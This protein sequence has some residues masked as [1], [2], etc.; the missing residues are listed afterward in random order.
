MNIQQHLFL[1]FTILVSLIVLN[2]QAIAYQEIEPKI[3]PW[4]KAP[5]K[6][7]L[8][9]TVREDI[10]KIKPQ[11]GIGVIGLRFIHQ[12]GYSTYIEQVYQNSPAGRAGIRPKDLIFAID[13]VRTDYLTSDGVFDMLSGEPGTKVKVFITRGQSMFNVELSR[14]DLANFSPEIQ[15]RYLSGPIAVPF[16]PKELFPYH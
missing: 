5:E 14:E 3:A 11:T 15:N 13:G 6:I 8:K 9:G 4:I 12:S 1:I 7:I 10:S 2:T 16:N